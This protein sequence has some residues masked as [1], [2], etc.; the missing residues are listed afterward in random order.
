MTGTQRQILQVAKEMG[1]MRSDVD[2]PLVGRIALIT[3]GLNQASAESDDRK[4][5]YTPTGF[6]GRLTYGIERHIRESGGRLSLLNIDNDEDALN[7]IRR[8]VRE[9]KPQGI[10]LDINGDFP[11]I[12]EVGALCP[13]VQV[14]APQGVIA[15]DSVA[16][17]DFGG[18]FSSVNRL[19]GLGHRRIG[20][21]VDEPTSLHHLMRLE[22]YRTA[23]VAASTGYEK[24]YKDKTSTQP[25]FAKRMKAVFDEI[26]DTPER[27][28]A[29]ACATDVFAHALL[30]LANEHGVKIPEELSISGFDNL[31]VSALTYPG[32]SSVDAKLEYMGAVAID[33]LSQR[34]A[35]PDGIFRQ[36]SLQSHLIERESTCALGG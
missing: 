2:R 28:T 29:V 22:G 21:V 23:M 20:F 25:M 14:N 10:V 13:V 8:F 6:Y 17:D 18:M 26:M 16:S 32:L 31:D 5:G 7:H 19:I 33:L 35:K 30:R 24:V 3:I 1:Y 27:P 36:V 9:E 15:V 34:I 12:G 11:G 4:L